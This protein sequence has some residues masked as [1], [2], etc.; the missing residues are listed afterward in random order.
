MR[1]SLVINQKK[2]VN[3]TA[4]VDDAKKEKMDLEYDSLCAQVV[5]D[6]FKKCVYIFLSLVYI[7][8]TTVLLLL[9]YQ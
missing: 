6:C 9:V 7:L 3:E 2:F 4:A 5:R 8:L 1:A